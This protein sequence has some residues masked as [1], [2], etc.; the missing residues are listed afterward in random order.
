M[1]A[2]LTFLGATR[3]VTGSRQTPHRPR[4]FKS[5]NLVLFVGYQV[6]GTL[7]RKLVDGAD[8]MRLFN[9]RVPVRAGVRKLGGLSGHADRNELLMASPA[10]AVFGR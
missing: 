5:A 4:A 2:S 8:E 3:S 1:T 7:G 10:P 6:S 9:R